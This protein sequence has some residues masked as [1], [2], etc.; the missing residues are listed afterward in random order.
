MKTKTSCVSRQLKLSCGQCLR[1]IADCRTWRPCLYTTRVLLASGAQPLMLD[2]VGVQ[3]LGLQQGALETCPF[4]INT[5]MGGSEKAIGISVQ[6]LLVKFQPH[7]VMDSAT[8]KVKAIATQVEC[9]DV[10]V[11]AMVLYPMGFTI[12][13]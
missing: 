9:Y 13:F 2:K 10:L 6:P 7:D 1:F 5:S 8:I 3:A 11:G 4:I 12:D